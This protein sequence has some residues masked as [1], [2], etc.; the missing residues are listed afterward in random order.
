MKNIEYLMENDDEA[1][2]LELKTD[3]SVV[4]RQALWAGIKPGM[5][6]A[7]IG[8]GSGKTTAIL[9][10]LA[11]PDGLA[12]GVDFS[13]T[14]IKHARQYHGEQGIE[15]VC[16]DI[17]AP[18][19]DLG[20]FDFIWVR[21]VL[22]YFHSQAFHIV[23]Q[24]T[25]II[26]PGGIL[27][28]IDLDHNCLNHAGLPPEMEKILVDIMEKLQEKAD[29]DPY[30]GRKLYS[31][32]YDLDY[33]DIYVDVAAHHLI[34]GKLKDADAFNWIKKLEVSTKKI[35]YD[36]ECYKGGYKGFRD[37]FEKFFTNPRRFTYSP[38]ICC[39]GRKTST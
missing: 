17:T 13:E 20:T 12:T 11:Q 24:L 2:R 4:E 10:K 37:D 27:C 5:R 14:R 1:V 33:E 30:A 8:C 39:R 35:G 36:F 3:T 26:R 16:A 23:K 18:L 25:E 9:H 15:F 6:V 7:D 22:E 19:N 28:L 21:F 32:L 29:F 31:F 34:Y 38:L